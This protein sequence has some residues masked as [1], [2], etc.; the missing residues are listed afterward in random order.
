L[1]ILNP[2]ANWHASRELAALLKRHRQLA[3]EMT[4]RELTER[5]AGHLGGALWALGHPLITVCVYLFLFGVVFAQKV[6]AKGI[7]LPLDYTV[8]MLAGLLP[9]LMMS[10]ALTKSSSAI[11]GNSN[12]VKQVVFPVEILPVK[13]VLAAVLTQCIFFAALVIY[14]LARFRGLPATMSLLPLLMLL[15]AMAAA[16]LAFAISSLACYLRDLREFVTVFCTINF[17]LMPVVF[18]PDMVPPIFR[19]FLYINPFSY[20]IWCY[21]DAIFFGRIEHPWAWIV[22]PVLSVTCLVVG[23]RTFRTLKIHFGN[24]L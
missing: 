12:L 22:F 8:Y 14:M 23:Y 3:W 4:R 17:F 15:Q 11:I 21:Q 5:F 20:M 18:L 10:E 16:G 6:E 19:P 1:S 7:S 24:V 13:V 2:A 9:W